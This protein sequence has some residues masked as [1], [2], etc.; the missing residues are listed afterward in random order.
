MWVG[1]DSKD[2][3]ISLHFTGDRVSVVIKSVAQTGCEY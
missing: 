3:R 2:G 1:T